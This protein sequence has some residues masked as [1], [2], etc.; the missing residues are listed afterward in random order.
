MFAV[1][2]DLAKEDDRTLNALQRDWKRLVDEEQITQSD[3]YLRHNRLPVLHIYGL[4]FK[5]IEVE[6]TA[7]VV[8]Y[9]CFFA[10][11]LSVSHRI[12]RN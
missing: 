11:L 7:K 5:N 1:G 9:V 12:I 4:G 2:Y 10:L 8:R 6:D 3:R